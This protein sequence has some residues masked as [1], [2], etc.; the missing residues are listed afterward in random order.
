MAGNIRQRPES[1]R[2]METNKFLCD[3]SALCV[4]NGQAFLQEKRVFSLCRA[5]GTVHVTHSFWAKMLL[6]FEWYR[7]QLRLNV[8]EYVF[9]QDWKYILLRFGRHPFGTAN[10][11][12]GSSCMHPRWSGCDRMSNWMFKFLFFVQ[13]FAACVHQ[14]GC[15]THF[16][17]SFSTALTLIKWMLR[18]TISI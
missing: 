12:I 17:Q 16:S 13:L 4:D 1:S 14:Y 9:G 15:N 10:V 3:A 7:N 6:A 8:I 18:S 2:I 5:A 11:R